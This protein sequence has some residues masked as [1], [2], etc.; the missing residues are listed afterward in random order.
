MHEA[1]LELL[2]CPFCG[3]RVSL[4]ENDS[5]VHVAT[6]I[7]SGVIGCECCAF[8]IVAG[9]PVMISN[10]T[11]KDAIR[12]LEAGRQEKALFG[13]LGLAEDVARIEAFQALFARR[14][15]AT[16]RE[17]LAI[18]SLDAEGSYFVYRLS[19]PTYIVAEALLQALGQ[20]RWP[21]AGHCL[22]LC[23]GL[24]HLTRILSNLRPTGSNVIA[25]LY[26]WKLWLAARFTSPACTPVCC[27]ANQPLPFTKDIFS[28]VVLADAFPYIWHK[29]LLSEEMIRLSGRDGVLVMPHL[30]SAHGENVS[31]GDTLTPVAYRN[32]FLPQQP[33][34]FSDEQ[35][36]AELLD[37]HTIDL[38]RNIS[39]TAFRSEPALTLIASRREDL[40]RPYN[41]P[42]GAEVFGEVTVNPLY[43]V[44]RRGKS[45]ILTLTFPT[46]EYEAEFGACRR[47]LPDTVTVDADLSRTIRP[48]ELGNDYAELRRRR[49]LIDAP[50]YY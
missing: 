41:V 42:D 17:A 33:R 1:M 5:L 44:E 10:D 11:T 40:F 36:F 32:L 31:A 15:P 39:P 37:H 48:T 46:P 26:F 12:A 19:D 25:D 47:Y 45:S 30:H 35:L 18:F 13:L 29:R 3:T 2:R 38:T 49:V 21:V 43:Q 7:D 6:R 50:L 23:G 24:G 9:I 22:D 34:L 16:F 20:Q 27:D 14:K 8:P 28:L 4:V